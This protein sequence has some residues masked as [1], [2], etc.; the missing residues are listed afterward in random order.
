VLTP[1]TWEQAK[2]RAGGKHG[3]KG[4]EAAITAI[5][6]ADLR[7]DIAHF[8]PDDFWDNDFNPDYD[9]EFDDD[10]DDEGPFRDDDEGP[11]RDDDRPNPSKLN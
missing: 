8:D 9:D 7:R 1:D 6:M 10:F 3:N 2:E 5:K 11:F 4:D